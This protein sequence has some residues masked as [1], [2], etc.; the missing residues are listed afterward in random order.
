MTPDL[1]KM[2]TIRRWGVATIDRF[3][4]KKNRKTMRFNSKHLCPGTLGVRAFAFDWIGEFNW[5]VPPFYLIGKTIIVTKFNS[6]QNFVKDY[7][8]IKDATRYIK[9]GDYKESHIGSENFKG[10]FIAFY[11]EK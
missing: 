3:A 10:Y 8:I 7:F 4:S 5:L 1:F 11:M 9:L 6:L 2:L